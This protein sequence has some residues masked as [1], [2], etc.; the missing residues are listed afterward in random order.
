MPT[1]T[2]DGKGDPK[3]YI[4]AFESQML[5]YT[6]TDAVW[7]KVFPMTLVGV[8]SDWFTNLP[9]G[10]IDC[11]DTLVELFTRQYIGNSARQRTS[12]EL[13]SVRQRKDKSLRDFVRRFNNEANT[14]PKL[15]QEIAFMALMSGL[16]DSD[17]KRYMA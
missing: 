11:F 10:S 13:M 12:G 8:A 5:L 1:C 6:D 16:A 9:P 3:R 17:F 4:A 2:Y 14:I 7:C 15:Q